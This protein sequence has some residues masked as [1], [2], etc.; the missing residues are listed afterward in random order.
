MLYLCIPF[1]VR[2]PIKFKFRLKTRAPDLVA[3]CNLIDIN[4]SLAF[5]STQG[6]G[7]YDKLKKT[8]ITDILDLLEYEYIKDKVST[9][10]IESQQKQK[11]DDIL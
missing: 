10:H 2:R 1:V 9:Y 11:Q 7:S 3:Q 5:L 8:D 6:Y 4:K